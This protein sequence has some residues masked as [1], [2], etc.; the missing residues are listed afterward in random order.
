MDELSLTF[1]AMK[2]PPDVSVRHNLSPNDI[3]A[4]IALHGEL[5]AG[6]YGWDKSFQ[7]HVAGPLTK[8]A[9]APNSRSK[10]WIVQQN[11]ALAGSIAIVETSRQ[12]AQ[13]RW[14]LL[15]SELRGKGIGR[16][17]VE[18]ALTF[19]RDSGY[20]SVFLWTESR[21]TAAAKLYHAFNFTLTE[22]KTHKLW[23]VT[24]TE[25]RYDLT[26]QV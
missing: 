22:Q 23:G 15:R 16:M 13:L 11:G 9:E 4:M 1:G 6:E 26:L 17:L 19:C 3:K 5:Y 24:A 10:V 21:L 2:L 14:L 20:Q 12:S 7:E 25:Q 18:D 8:F